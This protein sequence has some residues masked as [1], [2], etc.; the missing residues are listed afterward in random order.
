[1][2]LANWGS[3]S[4]L[5]WNFLFFVIACQAHRC[6][7]LTLPGRSSNCKKLIPAI[8]GRHLNENK[9]F[10]LMAWFCSTVDL[11]SYVRSNFGLLKAIVCSLASLLLLPPDDDTCDGNISVGFCV[12]L[13]SIS[14]PIDSREEYCMLELVGM[15]TWQHLG[16]GGL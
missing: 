2:H 6:H 8:Q 12:S 4:H 10:S 11:P 9:I 15:S 5:C 13:V 1:M 7:T 16:A 14:S 3:N